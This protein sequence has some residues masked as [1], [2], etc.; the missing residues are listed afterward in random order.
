MDEKQTF[1]NSGTKTEFHAKFRDENNSLPQ[2]II[3]AFT[4][5]GKRIS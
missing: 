2:K 3:L 5:N 4:I 1:Q